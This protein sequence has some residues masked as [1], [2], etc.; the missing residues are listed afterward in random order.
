MNN[1][2]TGKHLFLMGDIGCG[3][4]TLIK[5]E[6]KSHLD[7]VGG[8]YVQRI[9]KD[10]SLKGF[11]MC[12]VSEN[13]YTLD[14]HLTSDVCDFPLFIEKI[15]E[16]NWKIEENIFLDSFNNI[17]KNKTGKSLILMDEIGGF[18]LNNTYI[19][20]QIFDM[21]EGHIP[22]IG[23]IKS[24]K[25]KEVMKKILSNNSMLNNKDQNLAKLINHPNI[26]LLHLDNSNK[27]V[28]TEKIKS[29]IGVNIK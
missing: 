24:P 25:N 29:W 10:N 9:Y 22:I 18:E 7:K 23:V 8:F 5:N 3:K 2:K 16:T 15:T 26:E 6:L 4:S 12:N 1:F 27:A 21:L 17:F 13:D 11:R 28:I 14:Y 20:K 19:T